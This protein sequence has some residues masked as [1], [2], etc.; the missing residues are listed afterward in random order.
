MGYELSVFVLTAWYLAKISAEDIRCRTISN[1]AP[2]FVIAASPFLSCTL[3]SERILGLLALLI[4]LF[5]VNVMTN[6]FGMGDVKLCAAFGWTLGAVWGYGALVFALAGA[7]FVGKITH[8]SS[9]PL[10]PFI[11]F[12]GMAAIILKEMFLC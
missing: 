11:S 6:S 5:A 10:A 1:F 7:V 12:C 9:L 4:P 3:L 2:I 8:K